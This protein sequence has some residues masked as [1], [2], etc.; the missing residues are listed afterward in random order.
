MLATSRDGKYVEAIERLTGN[1]LVRREMMD[2]EVREESRPHRGNDR[3]GRGGK[4]ER[5]PGKDRHRDRRPPGGKFHDQVAG[6]EPAEVNVPVQ[7]EAPAQEQRPD[8]PQQ[9]K[10]RQD[11][12]RHEN[13]PRADAPRQNHPK[14]ER[15][16]QRQ[17]NEQAAQPAAVDHSELPAFLFRP[18]PVKKPEPQQ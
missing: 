11:K 5:R 13:R 15:G 6:M 14:R 8:K 3:H 4:G 16:S 12:P 2:I 17:H 10:P 9:D 1:K 18:V 7:A